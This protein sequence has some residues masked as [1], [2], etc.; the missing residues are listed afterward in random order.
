MPGGIIIFKSG[1]DP[2]LHINNCEQEWKRLG[3]RDD[4]AWPHIFPNTLDYL[5][6]KWYKI[7]EARGGLRPPSWLSLKANFIKDLSLTPASSEV[8]YCCAKSTEID[9]AAYCSRQR[10]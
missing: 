2:V 6:N 4:R 1:F 8:A 5:P 10:K 3:Y 9:R 7:E